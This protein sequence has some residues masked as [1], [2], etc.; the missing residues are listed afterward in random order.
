MYLS[1]VLLATLLQQTVGGGSD[2]KIVPEAELAPATYHT[3]AHKHWVW[4]H[5][6]QSNQQNATDMVNG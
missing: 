6:G 2:D 5:H 1:S 4:L 3:W